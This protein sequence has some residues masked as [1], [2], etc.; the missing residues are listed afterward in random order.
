VVAPAEVTT[1]DSVHVVLESADPPPASPGP[2]VVPF[3]AFYEA[4]VRVDC[5][6]ALQ[7][8]LAERW[9]RAR[10]GGTRFTLSADARFWNGEPVTAKDVA[11]SLVS[12]EDLQSITVEAD[13]TLVVR[14]RGD[15]PMLLAGTAFIV[16]KVQAGSTWPLGT[17]DYGIDT[18]AGSPD[19]V[20]EVFGRARIEGI[21]PFLRLTDGSTGDRRDVLDAGADV[22]VTR[23]PEALAYAR[24]LAGFD[25]TPLPWDR[26]YL[27]VTASAGT[28]AVPPGLRESFA[29]EIV[30]EDARPA[31][32]AATGALADVCPAQPPRLPPAGA[33]RPAEPVREAVI[34][35][36]QD[37]APAA[38]LAQ[39]LAALAGAPDNAWPRT[40]LGGTGLQ[41]L[42]TEGL[43]RSA[44]ETALQSGRNAGYV[45]PVAMGPATSGDRS[46]CGL[47]G[48][49]ARAPWLGERGGITPL[50]ETRPYLVRRRGVG[51]VLVD[52]FG[53]LRFV[54][55]VGAA[56]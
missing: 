56:R 44:F 14:H 49:A 55:P 43:S 8:G 7:P 3:P 32:G 51:P 35:Y 23:D 30:R 4:L 48:L 33:A 40:V 34:A 50:V 9:E 37:D 45:V 36:P 38:A 52:G 46:G 22:L 12:Y 1:V 39:R 29:R 47:A 10:D 28:A 2:A 27:L 53:A 17:G 20:R 16:A 19:R 42:R 18:I 24:R 54:P 13:R 26:R 31:A 21:P 25:L 6:G 5:T 15:D 41:R 11:A